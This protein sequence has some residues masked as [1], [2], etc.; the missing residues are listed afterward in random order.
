[1]NTIKQ[2]S[3]RT[4]INAFPVKLEPALSNQGADLWTVSKRRRMARLFDLWAQQL[5]VSAAVLS[6]QSRLAKESRRLA[7][8]ARN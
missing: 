8:L 4:T 7:R 6:A 5:R 3:Y 1:M 2:V